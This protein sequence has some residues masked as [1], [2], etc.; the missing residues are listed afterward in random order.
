M[1]CVDC[2]LCS[3]VPHAL[4]LCKVGAITWLQQLWLLILLSSLQPLDVVAMRQD[5]AL[6]RAGGGSSSCLAPAAFST[7]AASGC[8]AWLLHA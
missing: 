1:D 5:G 3:G 4:F 8:K 7:S 2:S 6:C